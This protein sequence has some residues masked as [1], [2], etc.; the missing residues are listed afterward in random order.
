MEAVMTGGPS[1]RRDREPAVGIAGESSRR[2]HADGRGHRP[3]CVTVKVSLAFLC[4]YWFHPQQGERGT[5]TTR[6]RFLLPSK[7]EFCMR[8]LALALGAVLVVG[9][10]LGTAGVASASVPHV[11]P[12]ITATEVTFTIPS[13]PTGVWQL[14][15]TTYPPPVTHLGKVQG[16]SGTS[17]C[18]SQA[19][20]RVP[21]RRPSRWRSPAHQPSSCTPRPRP[22]SQGA[23][24]GLARA[25]PP[26]T[27]R[28]T[29][30][31]PPPCC[32]SRWAATPSPPSLTRW[33][34]S[35]P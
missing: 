35:T 23:A 31:P 21:S 29:R 30:P 34:S 20:L 9:S 13:S 25:S 28:T 15:L 22:W 1:G 26:G 2:R 8:R 14:G 5:F 18:P 16:T 11:K 17:P 19:R 7:G 3:A 24:A 32:L 12:V 4:T 27:G 33:R 6:G 10:V